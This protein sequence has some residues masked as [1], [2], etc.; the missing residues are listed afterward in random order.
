MATWDEKRV[1]VGDTMVNVVYLLEEIE[2]GEFEVALDGPEVSGVNGLRVH[3]G[4]VY[5]S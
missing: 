2:T 4:D 5:A 1:L 3:E